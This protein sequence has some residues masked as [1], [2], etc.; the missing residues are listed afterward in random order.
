[1]VDVTYNLPISADQDSLWIP[2][3]DL[4]DNAFHIIQI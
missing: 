2:V 3:L 4:I 1:M